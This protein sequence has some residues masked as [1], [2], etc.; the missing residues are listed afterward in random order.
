MHDMAH[1]CCICYEDSPKRVTC[2]ANH[3]TCDSCL[4]TYVVSKARTLAKSNLLAAKADAATIANDEGLLAELGGECFCPLHGHGCEAARP[5]SDRDIAL[6]VSEAAFKE[7]VQAKALLPA[8]NRVKQVIDKRQELSMLLPDARQCGRCGC[9]PVL[10]DGCGDLTTHHGEIRVSRAT[11][12][13]EGGP[14]PVDNSCRRC[15]WF[16]E[17]ISEWPT[18]DATAAALGGDDPLQAAFGQAEGEDGLEVDEG[19]AAARRAAREQEALRFRREHHGEE[20]RE[21]H[22]AEL[23]FVRAGAERRQQRAAQQL[24]QRRVEQRRAEAHA[25]HAQH[26][27]R[28]RARLETLSLPDGVEDDAGALRHA[29]MRGAMERE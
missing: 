15:G 14:P 16:A 5:F 22:E 25:A 26:V 13:G 23:A 2:A 24:E 21:R 27:R 3:S 10:L 17:D 4:E 11:P 18:W 6:H 8:A 29:L 28:A 12:N 1:E 20:A 9:G 7:Y 19:E